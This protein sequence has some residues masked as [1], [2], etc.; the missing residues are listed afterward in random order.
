VPDDQRFLDSEF[1]WPQRHGEEQF[2]P[3]G[4]R[5]WR[6]VQDELGPEWRVGYLSEGEERVL[7]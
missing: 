7:W 5:L 6:I 3:G 4:Q 2:E 1:E